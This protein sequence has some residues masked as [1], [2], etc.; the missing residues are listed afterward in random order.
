MS[1]LFQKN[2]KNISNQVGEIITAGMYIEVAVRHHFKLLFT[3]S[4]ALPLL[5]DW[6]QIVRRKSHL[7]YREVKD[8][9]ILKIFKSIA[10][11]CLDNNKRHPKRRIRSTR[12]IKK[13]VNVLN[14]L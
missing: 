9:L 12:K 2:F 3:E 10:N 13:K 4:G 11:N 14:N 7:R 6:I 5:T 8:Y 1:D